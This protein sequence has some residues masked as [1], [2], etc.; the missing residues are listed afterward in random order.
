MSMP[1]GVQYGR[2]TGRLIRAVLDGSDGDESPD[3]APIPGATVTFRARV[4]HAK[5]ASAEPP[6]TIFL[7]PVVAATDENGVLVTRPGQPGVWLVATDDPGMDPAIGSYTVTVA[8]PTIKSLSWDI[9][10]PSGG[11]VDLATAAPVPSAPAA[12]L[13]E[14]AAVRGEV[15]AARDVA[16]AAADGIP[17]LVADAVDTLVGPLIQSSAE[18]QVPPIVAAEVGSAVLPHVQSAQTSAISAAESAT[19]AATSAT[20]AATSATNAATSA[21]NAVAAADR[22]PELV[23]DYLTANPPPP[24]DDGREVELQT[25]ATHVQWR[26]IGDAT[27]LDLVPLSVISGNDGLSAELRTTATHIQ[28]RQAGG[29][30]ADLIPLASLAGPAGPP[31]TAEWSGT[32]LGFNGGAKVD[33][34]GAPGGPKLIASYVHSGNRVLRVEAVNVGANTITITA[35]GL[36]TGNVLMCIP[37]TAPFAS[38]EAYLPTGVGLG[39]QG[40]TVIDAN[41]IRLGSTTLALKGTEDYTKWHFEL[42]PTMSIAGLNITTHSRA[43]IRY[44]G[45]FASDSSLIWFRAGWGVSAG[46]ASSAF[47]ADEN[48]GKGYGLPVYLSGALVF[49]STGNPSI[50][51][52]W[53]AAG[54]YNGSAWL[55]KSARIHEVS[56]LDRAAQP[57]GVVGFR[58]GLYLPNGATLEAWEV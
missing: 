34:R 42:R 9:V 30:W 40:V 48:T 57:L 4:R 50:E 15:L 23:A 36:S 37:E 16:V 49:D 47:L 22:I 2:V 27:W 58:G 10:V 5:K 45:W 43:L 35:H 14:W 19:N 12:A 32:S 29:A 8:A 53:W 38:Y 51:G 3:G 33:L 13:A 55:T 44:R 6:V 26:Y 1:S 28:W 24:G 20:N 21:T 54:Q 25:S 17:E 56:N 41:T 18:A 31:P 46:A 39:Q 52:S 7:D 11:T